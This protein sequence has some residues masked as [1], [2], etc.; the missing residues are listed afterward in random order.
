MLYRQVQ[1]ILEYPTYLASK[2]LVLTQL[3]AYLIDIIFVAGYRSIVLILLCLWSES[4]K[5]SKISRVNT[6]E[7]AEF[8]PLEN[9]LGM[10]IRLECYPANTSRHKRNVGHWQEK[11]RSAQ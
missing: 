1:G 4:I 7:W 2:Q 10:Q 5:H 6:I 3:T 11:G 9:A 8:V